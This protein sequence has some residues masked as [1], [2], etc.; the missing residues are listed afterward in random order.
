MDGVSEWGVAHEVWQQFAKHHQELRVKSNAYAFHNF[1]RR[2]KA[3]LVAADAIRI[4][5]GKHWIAHRERFNQVAF[6]LLTQREVDSEL[7]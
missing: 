4:A 6:E 7:G 2:A 3:P 1:L 5:N